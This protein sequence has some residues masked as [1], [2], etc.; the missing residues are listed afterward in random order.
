MN[1]REAETRLSNI[2]GL[3]FD[4]DGVL[5]VGDHLIDQAVETVALVREAGIERRFITNTSTLS[6]AAMLQRMAHMGFDIAPGELLSAPQATVAYLR[7]HFADAGIGLL[8]ADDV[9]GD[10]V[11]FRCVALDAADCIVIGD[12]GNA[13][14]SELLNR[15]FNRLMAGAR[16]I[17]IHKN[18]FWQTEQGL[19]MDVGGF[20][21]ALEYCSGTQALV[22]GKPSPTF[23]EVALRDMALPARLTAIIG[24]DIYSDIEGGQLAGLTGIL[25]RTGKYRQ[26]H[27]QASGIRPDHTIDSIADLPELIGLRR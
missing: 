22:M 17:V 18:R 8:L 20:V 26:A 15:V 13:W 14:T 7:D 24:D 16:L 5:Y 2:R 3:L 21:T 27:V 12:I 9:K 11:E 1:A 10:F 19:R 4:L 25:V 23:F 6:Q